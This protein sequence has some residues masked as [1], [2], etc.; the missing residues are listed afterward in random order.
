MAYDYGGINGPHTWALRFPAAG[1]QKQSPINIC[2]SKLTIDTSL[3]PLILDVRSITA[4]S[5]KIGSHNFQVVVEGDGVLKGGPLASEYTFAQFHFH[6]GGGN[7]W[8]SEHLIDGI[9]SPGEL[10]CVFL[11]KSYAD[12][13]AAFDYPDGLVVIGVL[14]KLSSTANPI[15]QKLA[16]LLENPRS[17]ETRPISPLLQLTNLFPKDLSKY[18]TYSGSLTTPPCNECVTWIVLD[19]PLLVSE[20]VMERLRRVHSRCKNCGGPDNFR[21]ICPL[22]SRKIVA[23]F[24]PASQ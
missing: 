10:H 23:S 3:K 18:Y 2:H 4:Q 19:E 8:G 1:G 11:N 6:W 21:P 7:N 17:G 20:D 14:F 5:L 24:Q 16:E 15:M 12:K 13:E 9:S 22:G